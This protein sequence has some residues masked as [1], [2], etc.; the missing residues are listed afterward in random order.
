MTEALNS[1][2]RL[3]PLTEKSTGLESKRVTRKHVGGVP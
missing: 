2:Q 1:P 3:L